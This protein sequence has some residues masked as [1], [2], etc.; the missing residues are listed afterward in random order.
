ML[1]SIVIH[2]RPLGFVSDCFLRF[3]VAGGCC[4]VL[5]VTHWSPIVPHFFLRSVV[6]GFDAFLPEVMCS[7]QSNFL[8]ATLVRVYLVVRVPQTQ[9]A[10]PTGAPMPYVILALVL[11]FHCC[12]TGAL[13]SPFPHFP[14]VFLPSQSFPAFVPFSI[15]AR[16]VQAVT[17]VV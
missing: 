12:R 16:L 1:D 7:P 3:P 5:S 11:F 10:T 4:F 13:P 9:L 2:T 17:A 8:F 14:G 15:D 6:Q